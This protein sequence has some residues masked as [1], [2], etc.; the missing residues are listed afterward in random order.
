MANDSHYFLAI[1]I[2]DDL[3]EWMKTQQEQFLQLSHLTYKHYVD[4][5]D[6][7]ITLKFLGAVSLEKQKILINELEQLSN[8]GSFNL[9]IGK[10][11]YF[12]L[13]TRPRVCWLDVEKNEPLLYLYNKIESISK[14]IG[15][16]E[17]KR[18]YQPHITL[19]KKWATGNLIH[20]RWDQIQKQ[21]NEE[22]SFTVDRFVLYRVVPKGKPMYKT[23]HE[24][25]L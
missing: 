14:T 23:V 15:F 9:S 18:T 11:G 20:E 8:S 24:V 4:Y 2:P 22:K 5:A 13:Q 3:K 12:G 21:L 16:S 19:V 17:E 25:K 7:H 10:F 6:F 1:P